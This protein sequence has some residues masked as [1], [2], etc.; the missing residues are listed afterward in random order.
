MVSLLSRPWWAWMAPVIL[1]VWTAMLVA[2]LLRAGFLSP[3]A[4]AWSSA[5]PLDGGWRVYTGQAPHVD[6]H[7]PIGYLYLSMVAWAMHLW[8]AT[9]HA[10]AQT[11]VLTVIP[12]AAAAWLLSS[13]RLPPLLA[14]AVAA[15]I[16]MHA[17]SVS[18]FGASQDSGISFSGQ[19]SRLGWAIFFI[20]PMHEM[21]S[22]TRPAARWRV[23][24]EHVV[25]GLAIGVLFGLK[26]TYCAAALACLLVARATAPANQRGSGLMAVGAGV[27]VAI[28]GGLWASGASLSGY[29][30]DL[31]MAKAS[32]EV[33]LMA[34]LAAEAMEIDL[35]LS[36]LLAV[37]ALSLWTSE[38][39][40][41][42]KRL[43][44]LMRAAALLGLGFGLSAYNGTEY[45]SPIY[46]VVLVVL[47]AATRRP[48]GHLDTAL[49]AV[50]LVA[51]T[52]SLAQPLVKAGLRGRSTPPA[53]DTIAHGPYHGV[54]FV[55][56]SNASDGSDG[57]IP[58]LSRTPHAILSNAYLLWLRE[59]L[60]HL[61]QHA[62]P[63]AVIATMDVA[64]PFPFAL[65]TPSPRGDLV[66]WHLGR[67]VSAAT[68][69]P[70][71]QVLGSV[72][73]VMVPKRPLMVGMVDGKMAIYGD[74]VQRHFVRIPID[75]VWW[76]ELW[77]RI[78]AANKVDR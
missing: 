43:L 4:F 61:A 25:V 39:S 56:G 7:S 34:L 30:S 20:I 59:G 9:P 57:L 62:P 65:G 40:S 67:N 68:A 3:T 28:A 1:L 48:R 11:A 66:L 78:P 26:V 5:I 29:L 6:F 2:C 52:L 38:M 27:V 69:P 60:A 70:A 16:T 74:Y 15:F 71:D 14:L 31:A 44:I 63:D 50:V 37:M 53:S 33:S 18:F 75:S 47:Y 46:A 72:T 41:P 42:R 58:A 51:L 19:Y 17:A 64:N 12:L 35:L 76:E 32:S 55:A 73:V 77:L 10:L 49:V 22:P 54:D 23:Q 21:L 8:G 24:A 45:V 36:G 13:R